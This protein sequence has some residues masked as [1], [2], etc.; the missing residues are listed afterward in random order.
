[1]VSA[2]YG[3][4]QELSAMKVEI[5]YVQENHR[6]ITE[7]F[8]QLGRVLTEVAVQDNRIVMLEKY[9]DELRHGDGFVKKH[10]TIA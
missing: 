6:T 5:K 4:K 2:F 9:I 1:M 3:L 7:A 10:K 8:T